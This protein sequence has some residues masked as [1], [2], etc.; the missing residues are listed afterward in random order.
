MYISFLCIPQVFSVVIFFLIV[1]CINFEIRVPPPPSN[2]QTFT[3]IDFEISVQQ[4]YLKKLG[5]RN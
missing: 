3:Q 4:T 2:K 1:F 5:T